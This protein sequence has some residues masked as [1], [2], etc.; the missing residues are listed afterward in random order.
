MKGNILAAAAAL[1]LCSMAWAAAPGSAAAPSA[2]SPAAVGGGGYIAKTERG[3]LAQQIV[4]K[5]SGYVYQV[6][7]TT[8][9]AWARAMGD[10]FAQADISNLRQAAKRQTF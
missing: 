4:R 7:E 1:T 3:R 2:K 9:N 10:T 5:W 6:Y 8:P